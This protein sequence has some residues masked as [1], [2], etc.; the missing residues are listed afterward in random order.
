MSRNFRLFAVSET[1]FAMKN[2]VRILHLVSI[3]LFFPVLVFGAPDVLIR[4]ANR[5]AT[6]YRQSLE[7]LADWARKK[8]FHE[9]AVLT[10]KV[11]T[12]QA[13]DKLYFPNFPLE[14]GTLDL[15]RGLPTVLPREYTA[16]FRPTEQS[17]TDKVET[18]KSA[19]RQR[20]L[21][22]R[23]IWQ[24][25]FRTLRQ[26]HARS[27]NAMA[28]NAA[29]NDRGTLAIQMAVVGLQADPDHPAFRNVF[30]YTKYKGQWRTPWEADRLRKN[31]VDHETFGWMPKKAVDRYEK[32]E[33]Y[34]DGKWVSA[35]EEARFRQGRIE[36]GWKIES[37]HYDLY[38]NHSIEEGVRL[39]RRLEDVYQ[40]WKLTFFRYMAS[41]PQLATLFDGKNTPMPQRRHRIVLYRNKEDFHRHLQAEMNIDTSRFA[42][43]YRHGNN[44]DGCYFYSVDPGAADWERQN[45]IRT[46][47]HEATHQL[48]VETRKSVGAYGREQNYWLVEGVATFMESLHREGDDYYVLGGSKDWRLQSARRMKKTQSFDDMCRLN[49]TAFVNHDEMNDLYR[50]SAAMFHF[51]FFFEDGRWRDPLTVYL[52]TVYDAKDDTS[53]LRK[54][55]GVS[56][57]ELDSLFQNYLKS[58]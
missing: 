56:Y 46:M 55:T 48:F 40:V 2:A 34:L 35:D 36:N 11:I 9:E 14:T 32:G 31:Y 24:I 12:P 6:E 44:K 27:L 20:E 58:R 33:R 18:E 8:G 52:R 21:S 5:A 39:I 29:K 15:P 38:T 51:L 4:N 30:G 37:E 26:N 42:G 50:Q 19:S 47:Y 3:F 28:R 22:D 41:D 16:L 57:D 13:P 17:G 1:S 43:F 25:Q 7:Q 49:Y 53:T 54:L 45:V 23:E 10:L